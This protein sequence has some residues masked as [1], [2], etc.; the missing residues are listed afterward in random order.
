MQDDGA[1]SR[2][3]WNTPDQSQRYSI[4]RWDEFEEAIIYKAFWMLLSRQRTRLR[5]IAG[6]AMLQRIEG[7]ATT[8]M[9]KRVGARAYALPNNKKALEDRTKL[10]LCKKCLNCRWSG[11]GKG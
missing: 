8:N 6:L 3:I 4:K 5:E 11:L 9:I 2:H 1:T 7:S 10:A